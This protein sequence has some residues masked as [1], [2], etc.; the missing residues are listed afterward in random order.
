M[1]LRKLGNSEIAV[2]AIGMGC[3]AIVGDATWGKQDEAD[4]LAAIEAALDSGVNFFDTAEI[5]GNGFSEE[6]LGKA[7]LGMRD[8]VVIAT[9]ASAHHH[10]PKALKRACEDSLRRLRTDYVDVYQL[11]WPSREVPF[12]DTWEAM[13]GLQQEGKIR[14]ASVSNFGKADL[15]ALL[16][17]GT[18]A[19]N[20][21]C[22]SLLFRAI[23]FELQPLCVDGSVGIICYSPLM[24]GLLTGKFSSADD[25]P[26]GRA[27]T[28]HFSKDRLQARHT[29]EGLE[30]ETFSAIRKMRGICEE[31]GVPMADAALAW[32]LAQPAVTAV[33][34]SMRNAAQAQMNA[35]AGDLQL[36]DHVLRELSKVTE[37]IKERLGSNAD[38]WQTESRLS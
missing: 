26:E 22:Y 7:F 9:K 27:R 18:P 17:S 36:P 15:T 31:V 16:R 33:I 21:L 1:Q 24:Q 14:A 5:Y 3:W 35:R 19:S 6:I 37:E 13:R 20:Q 30:E 28:R 12:D 38:M 10:E 34:P 29:E 11:H 8:K 2:S 32:L 25:V 23:E 4:T